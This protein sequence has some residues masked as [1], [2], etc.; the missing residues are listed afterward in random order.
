MTTHQMS[1]RKFI[2]MGAMT[3]GA[4]VVACSGLTLAGLYT[5]PVDFPTYKGEGKMNGKVLVAYASVC[6]STAEVAK[7]IA[8][9]LTDKGE[10]VDL[11]QAK[12]VKDLSSYKSVVLGSAIRMGKWKSDATGFVQRFQVELSQKPT[13]FFTVCL[14]MV[15]DTDGNRKKVVTYLDPVRD[16]VKPGKEGY[17]A[18]KLDYSKLNFIE[19]LIMKNMRKAPEGDFRK[20]DLIKA[21]ASELA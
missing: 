3:V 10:T 17:F 7:E 5:P 19:R 6:G 18:G 11:I 1:R 15:D 20:W 2:Q 4:T 21:W 12:D 9:V 14:T 16:I 8:S 13:A